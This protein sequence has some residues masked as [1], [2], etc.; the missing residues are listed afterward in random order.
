MIHVRY[1]GDGGTN[2]RRDGGIPL[3]PDL[4]A[5]L[6]ELGPKESKAVPLSNN[7]VED[8]FNRHTDFTAHRL[9]HTF[10]SRFIQAE[11]T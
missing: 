3:H 7:H 11:A 8:W 2:S 5:F 9:R 4:R 1:G 6:A 10:T